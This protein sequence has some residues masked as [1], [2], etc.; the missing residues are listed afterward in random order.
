M[1]SSENSVKTGEIPTTIRLGFVP[2][3]IPAK[4]VRIWRERHPDWELDLVALSSLD[5]GFA[6]NN[7]DVDAALVRPPL[8]TRDLH[9]VVLY[10][11]VSVVVFPKDHHFAAADELTAQDLSEEIQ[12]HPLDTPFLWRGAGGSTQLIGREAK[13]RPQDTESAIALV[14]AGIGIVVVP[15]SLARLHHR[16][17]LTFLPLQGGPV[18][19]VALVWRKDDD[20]ELIEEFHG[21]V[22]G[23]TPNSSRGA[24]HQPLEGKAAKALKAQ[25]VAERNARKAAEFVAKHGVKSSSAG[26]VNASKSKTRAGKPTKGKPKGINRKKS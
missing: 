10:E 21:I 23:R 26:K 9:A 17:D 4:W 6:T 14:A 8:L 19:P 25:R 5:R 1:H 11:E 20:R 24:N 18:A 15:Q 12:L 16:K 7:Q 2:G 13:E 3:V 22:R